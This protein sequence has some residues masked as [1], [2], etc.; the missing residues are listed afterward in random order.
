M[1][2]GSF[3]PPCLSFCLS[4]PNRD[5]R[6][7]RHQG[8]VF[9]RREGNCPGEEILTVLTLGNLE[10]DRH[11][12][13]V[14]FVYSLQMGLRW[15]KFQSFLYPDIRFNLLDRVLLRHLGRVGRCTWSS[16]THSC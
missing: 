1:I 3:V 11:L 16:G 2:P 9:D 8:V 13:K 10:N 5:F 12:D 15:L 4:A 7:V 6:T 14:L